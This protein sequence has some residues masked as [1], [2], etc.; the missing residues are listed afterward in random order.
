MALETGT[1]I[2]DLNV[3]NPAST[4]GLGQADDHM[5]LI[6]ATVKNTFPNISNAVTSTHGELNKMDG[7]TTQE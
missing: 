3:N 7:G 4:D 2:D 6:K 5:R 1:Y